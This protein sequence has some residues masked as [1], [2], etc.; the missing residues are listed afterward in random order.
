[1]STITNIGTDTIAWVTLAAGL[2]FAAL[3]A[4]GIFSIYKLYTRRAKRLI[5][6]EPFGRLL[7]RTAT[8]AFPAALFFLAFFIAY[9]AGTPPQNA[10][11]GAG[12][13]AVIEEQVERE[14]TRPDAAPAPTPEYEK[15][16]KQ[17]Q[18]ESDKLLEDKLKKYRPDGGSK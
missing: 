12:G 11:T 6:N 14:H 17:I 13:E 3:A 8:Y 18:E 9:G 10:Y 7:F 15:D 5:D 1:M 16:H 4:K 2:I